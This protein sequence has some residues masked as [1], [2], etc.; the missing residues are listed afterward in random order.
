MVDVRAE[1]QVVVSPVCVVSKAHYLTSSGWMPTD[2]SSALDDEPPF[3]LFRD[4]GR[5]YLQV[6]SNSSFVQNIFHTIRNFIKL[7]VMK[8]LLTD[9]QIVF[10]IHLSF[11]KNLNRFKEKTHNFF[12]RLDFMSFVRVC[13]T[14]DRVL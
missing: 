2:N 6:K 12:F 5:T 8:I 4:S 11:P 7:I 13:V 14:L 1:G 3:A 10:K 9:F